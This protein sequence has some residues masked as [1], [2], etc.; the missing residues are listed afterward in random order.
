MLI[1]KKVK[2]IV[3]EAK[4][5]SKDIPGYD[6]LKIL[7]FWTTLEDDPIKIQKFF[8]KIAV[9]SSY[10]TFMRP[11][12]GIRYGIDKDG[13][14]R[15]YVVVNCWLCKDDLKW[16]RLDD[17]VHS[18][19]R[20]DNKSIMNCKSCS[21]TITSI[22]SGDDEEP[23]ENEGIYLFVFEEVKDS[24]GR[25]VYKFGISVDWKN[26]NKGTIRDLLG[27]KQINFYR[28]V[29][30]R[31]QAIEQALKKHLK[32]MN[33]LY[34]KD[35]LPDKLHGYD[36]WSESF[37]ATPHFTGDHFRSFCE[38]TDKQFRNNIKNIQQ[39]YIDTRNECFRDILIP[40]YSLNNG[41]YLV[42]LANRPNDIL[43]HAKKTT[44][45]NKAGKTE[46]S[47]VEPSLISDLNNFLK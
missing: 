27:V 21:P 30:E 14:R 45:L 12:Y 31:A 6:V 10:F 39:N 5:K 28:I 9:Q 11:E 36:G 35:N 4:E 17:L 18:E 24:K 44:N 16:A 34:Q 37:I 26:R 19:V 46:L 43:E 22:L 40:D 25:A 23:E 2:K 32:G 41:K 20:K 42:S 7:L 8:D 1:D 33:L 15:R 29:K 38:T 13:H 3:A 47:F